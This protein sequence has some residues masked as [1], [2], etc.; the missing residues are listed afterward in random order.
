MTKG[1]RLFALALLSV[2][3]LAA[4]AQEQIG[5]II[6][7]KG[8][9][10]ARSSDGT[11]R[12]VSRRSPLF[13][14]DTLL[15]GSDGFVD[16]RMIDDAHFSLPGNTEFQF[17]T[18]SFDGDPATPDEASMSMVRGCFRTLSGSIG[19]DPDSYRIDT[20]FGS[21]SVNGTGH[22][23][24]VTENALYTHTYEGSTTVSNSKGSLVVGINSSYDFSRTLDGV[25]PEGL[26]D[27]P[28][29]ECIGS[30]E[31]IPLPAP[32]TQESFRP[33]P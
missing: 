25:A 20:P 27:R 15:T 21:I 3:T 14:Q 4:Q 30:N 23:A 9:V 7:T 24:A 2:W 6:V 12:T 13:E 11:V 1:S 16:V 31:V 18:Y 22:A 33:G 5:T 10:S 19:A 26:I 29:E 28:D 8:Q 32:S 17:N